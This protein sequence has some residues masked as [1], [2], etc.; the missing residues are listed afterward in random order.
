MVIALTKACDKNIRHKR[1]L[2]KHKSAEDSFHLPEN[3]LEGGL[4]L[5]SVFDF[6]FDDAYLEGN[7]THHNLKRGAPCQQQLQKN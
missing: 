7:R 2:I 5:P 6:L 1:G 4:H 3:H